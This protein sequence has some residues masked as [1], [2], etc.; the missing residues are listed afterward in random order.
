MDQF[1]NSINSGFSDTPFKRLRRNRSDKYQL[2]SNLNCARLFFITYEINSRA[3]ILGSNFSWN[4]IGSTK[5]RYIFTQARKKAIKVIMAVR[6]F[7]ILKWHFLLLSCLKNNSVAHWLIR[8]F[9]WESGKVNPASTPRRVALKIFPTVI[10]SCKHKNKTP[11]KPNRNEM[12]VW[13]LLG[14]SGKK[15]NR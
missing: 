4:F 7:Q 15:M 13:H 2:K 8:H 1:W 9:V 12:L 3:H 5:L 10:Y 6:D 11:N 14:W